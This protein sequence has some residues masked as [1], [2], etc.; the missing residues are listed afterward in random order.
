[1]LI[2][3][4]VVLLHG[5]SRDPEKNEDKNIIERNFTT[6]EVYHLNYT[7]TTDM[8]CKNIFI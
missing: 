6:N 5:Y 7:V 8:N 4:L 3:T 2:P 1:M